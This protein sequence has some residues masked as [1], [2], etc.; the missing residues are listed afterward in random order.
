[1]PK[2]AWI[3][4]LLLS[5]LHAEGSKEL[6]ANNCANHGYIQ[7]WDNN[8]PLR[9]FATYNCAPTHRLNIRVKAGERIYFGYA[10]MGYTDVWYRLRAP[11][12]AIVM[13]GNPTPGNPGWIS[14]CSEALVGPDQLFGAGGYNPLMYTAL[15]SGDYYIEFAV[16][17]N[18]NIRQARRFR[19]F[20]ITVARLE[21][22]VWVP[23]PGRVWSKNWD[24]TTNGG[25]NAFYGTLY[26]Y[27]I[28]SVVTSFEMNGI[29]PYGFEVTCNSFGASNVGTPQQ[30][31]RSDFR[32]NIL[33][34][35]GIP[36]APEYPVFLNNPDEEFFPTGM[37]AS[38]DSFSVIPCTQSSYCIYVSVSKPATVDVVLNFSGGY[39]PVVFS[40]Y[41][42]N[43]GPNC[44]PWD[45]KDGNGTSVAD[46]TIVNAQLDLFTG[47]THLPLTD[48]ENHPNGFR[49]NLVRPT[50]RPNGTPL[51]TPKLYWDDILI[52]TGTALDGNVN[53]AGCDPSSLP[54]GQGCHR[55][56]NRGAN[57]AN[58]EVINTWWY[59][60]TE[61]HTF[62]LNID[63]TKWRVFAEILNNSCSADSVRIHLWFS[64]DI[65]LSSVNWMINTTPPGI[66]GAPNIVVYNSDSNWTHVYLSYGYTGSYANVQLQFLVQASSQKYP[67]CKDQDVLSCTILPAVLTS[68]EGKP[69][70]THNLLRWETAAEK[71]LHGYA[72][73][74][75]TDGLN[76]SSIGWRFAH[77][78][79]GP[80]TFE[81]FAPPQHALYRLR[82]EDLT[83]GYNYSQTVEILREN[84]LAPTIQWTQ[85]HI[86]VQ[87]P[88]AARLELYTLTG[89]K[90][91]EGQAVG[92]Y[93]IPLEGL[94]PGMYLLYIQ[95][96][97]GGRY[98][99]KGT[100]Y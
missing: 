74:R 53:L 57:N 92:S 90:I 41:S 10:I 61:T 58:P 65:P 39:T 82:I 88:Y 48:V 56:Q 7:I 30:R 18:P 76:F 52:T 85:S 27:S 34:A 67:Y 62:T 33:N 37:V 49:V 40:S 20:D 64:S 50:T 86:L 89:Q 31:R 94:S 1:M 32:Q 68:F 75:S 35:G 26:A 13:S 97:Q 5:Y 29:L 100:I 45:G 23:K 51:P 78:A 47:L 42:L 36:G 28:D 66:L 96:S 73:E 84:A 83:G 15:M 4:F 98:Q 19:D 9:Q 59:T 8:D 70:P 2:K 14:I 87:L 79:A 60:N 55:W 11:N 3:G 38:V 71:D 25:A 44:I 12:G 6:K 46:G 43:A 95:D 22:G 81:D 16:N 21:N 72:I 24:F 69:L 17:N 77:Q 91:W 93:Q 80:Y 63:P 99:S 54:P